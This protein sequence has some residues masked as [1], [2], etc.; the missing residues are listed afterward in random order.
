MHRGLRLADALS[1]IRKRKSLRAGLSQ[2]EQDVERPHG[3]R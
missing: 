1:N 3:V 2:D